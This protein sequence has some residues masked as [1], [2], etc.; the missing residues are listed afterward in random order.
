RTPRLPD[1]ALR[2]RTLHSPTGATGPRR[3]RGRPAPLTCRARLSRP[4]LRHARR[5]LAPRHG[6][7]TESGSDHRGH[8][9]EA[10]VSDPPPAPRAHTAPHDGEGTSAP[11]RPKTRTSALPALR[12]RG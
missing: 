1:R 7:L 9:E 2:R 8:Q 3:P 5:Y 6:P 12:S 10:C 11:A 4:F